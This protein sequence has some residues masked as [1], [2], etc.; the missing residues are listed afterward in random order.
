[1]T[2][3]A[4][5]GV[6]NALTPP[7]V[8]IASLLLG[9]V[10]LLVIGR[11]Q[12]FSFDDWALLHPSLDWWASHQGHWTTFPTLLFLLL[13]STVGLHSYLPYL[14]LAVIAHLAVVH[15][16]WRLSLRAGAAP[17]L[18]AG[19]A[20]V[21]VLLGCAAE[22]LFWAFQVGFMGAVAV[23]LVVVLLVDR[24]G[25]SV[26]RAVLTAAVA[27]LALPFSGTALPVLAGAAVLCWIRRGFLR[28]L[29]VFAPAGV[30]YLIWYLLEAR[31][32]TSA[33]GVHGIGFVTQAPVF[34]AVMFAAGY[35]QFVGVL[36]LGP[37]VAL[38]LLV[39]LWFARHRWTGREA[40]AYS[41]LLSSAVFA[42]LT[43]VSRGG[44]ELT[45]A[46]AQRY[47]YVIV[48][49][50]IPTMAV[51]LTRLATIR[52]VWRISVAAALVLIAGVNIWL[53][54]VRADAQAVTE[55]RVQR[56]LSAAI[57]LL[58]ADPDAAPPAAMPI[59]AV[60]PDLTVADVTA[61]V[62][63]RLVSPV[64]F[65]RADTEAVKKSLGV[66]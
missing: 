41:L 57:A 20:A 48:M 25:W 15:L 59:P 2:D 21:T 28:T 14:A 45:A 12:W 58:D 30:V 31:D 33:L 13:R 61:D 19:F 65:G 5:G 27:V 18:A 38:A 54:V 39:W 47:V 22:N 64:P 6:R 55:Q 29:A 43:A 62:R 36:V 63:D 46:G 56:E 40:V 52:R 50:A 9:A 53:S 42:A 60:A 24:P 23:A 16:I 4:T 66:P 8:H 32:D 3:R 10:A 49:L 1:M 17:W 26:R 35:G 51:A 37:L 7:R 11:D 44:G 34:F